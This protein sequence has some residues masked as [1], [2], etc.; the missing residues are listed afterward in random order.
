[1]H[2]GHLRASVIGQ[3]IVNLA[4]SQ[5]YNVVGLN[6]LGDWGVQFGKLVWAYQK[7]GAGYDFAARPFESLYALYVRFHVEAEK[8]PSLN[9][10]GSQIFKR[11]EDGDA[12]IQVLWRHFVD[13]SLKDY[14]RIWAQLGVKHDLIR[15]RIVLQ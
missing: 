1:M 4:K 5:S 11:L 7:W 10:A 6:H 9:D 14:A 3:A 2:V 13:I 8:D 15:G 12:E